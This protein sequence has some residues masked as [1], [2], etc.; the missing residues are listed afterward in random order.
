MNARL[1]ISVAIITLNEAER[2]GRCLDSVQELASEVVVVDS[3]STDQTCDLARSHGARVD[4]EPWSGHVAQKNKALE[5]C[6]EPWVLCLDADEVVSPELAA[7]IRE[8][9]A[10]GEPAVGGFEFNRL[11]WYLGEWI[12]HSWYPEWRLRLVRRESARWAGLDPHDKLTV[13]GPVKRLNGDLLHYSFRDLNDHLTR[14]IKYARIMATS[15]AAQGRHFSWFNLLGSPLAAIFKHLITKQGFRDGWRGWVIAGVKAIDA[16]A[17]YS[18][19]LET[20]R[21]ERSKPPTDTSGI[22]R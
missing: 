8:H 12:W 20:E 2:L 14:T 11:T 17:K 5:R 1:P 10:A 22:G 9:F 16:F 4:V 7:S 3:G 18:F 15:Y 21:A 13:S 19:L 6:R